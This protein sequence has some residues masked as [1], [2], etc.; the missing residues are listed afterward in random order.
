MARFAF[1]SFRIWNIALQHPSF[2]FQ[3]TK[4]HFS[5]KNLY[6]ICGQIYDSAFSLKIANRDGSTFWSIHCR[7][8]Q[9]SPLILRFGTPAHLLNNTTDS[10]KTEKPTGF[11]KKGRKSVDEA[12]KSFSARETRTRGNERNPNYVNARPVT[13]SHTMVYY[14]S[15]CAVFVEKVF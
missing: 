2:Y 10:E 9:S 4:M 3:N 14:S 13:A 7:F 8:L 12:C 11:P 6:Y 5:Y 1:R 15:G